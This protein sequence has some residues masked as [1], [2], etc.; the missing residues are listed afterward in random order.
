VYAEVAPPEL[1]P[2]LARLSAARILTPVAPNSEH[3]AVR[4]EIFHDVLAAAILDWRS[5]YVRDKER[6]LVGRQLAVE[7]HRVWH[8]RRRVIS[9]SVLLIAVIVLAIIALVQSE[10]V[11]NAQQVALSREASQRL[12]SVFVACFAFG[13]LLTL[14]SALLGVHGLHVGHAGGHAGTSHGGLRGAAARRGPAPFANPSSFLAFLTWFGAA[15]YVLE[16]YAEWGLAAVLGGAI[17]AGV[18]GWYVITR[19]LELILS[20]EREMNP[21][22][23]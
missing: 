6:D 23:Y 12:E 17:A 3:A 16:R 21:E 1:D 22:D 14:F 11:G 4:Y 19:F 15:G 9:L 18:A 5:R 7:Q 13:A 20:G 2:V 10:A 8:L